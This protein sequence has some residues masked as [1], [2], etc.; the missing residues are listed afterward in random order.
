MRTFVRAR[1]DNE[2]GV[3]LVIV[4]CAMV[5]LIGMLAIA[6]DG[7]YGFVQNRRAQNASDFAAF[8]AAQELNDSTYCNGSEQPTVQ[9]VVAVIEN[10]IKTNDSSVGTA[11]KAKFL[12]G[13]PPN[14]T[15]SASFNSTDYPS[16]IPLRTCGVIVSVTPSWPSFFAGI[17]GHQRLGGYA[18]ATVAPTTVSNSGV[19]IVA[20]NEAGPH[21]VL[22]GGTGQFIVEGTIFLNTNVSQQ[23]WS[24]SSASA[25]GTVDL[26][27]ESGIVIT[28]GVNDTIEVMDNGNP[29][30][31]TIAASTPSGYSYTALQSALA[32]AIS[33]DGLCPYNPCQLNAGYNYNGDLVL[34]THDGISTASDLQVTGGDARDT[35]GLTTPTYSVNV[36]NDAV[37]A[38]ANS[39]LY[40]YGTIDTNDGTPDNGESMWPLDNC[41]EP[42]G[43]NP[44]V[45]GDGPTAPGGG[46][47]AV[48]MSCTTASS[49]VTVDYNAVD[50]QFPQESDPLNPQ[51]TKGA[52][53]D[54]A[55]AANLPT[56]NCPGM[57]TQY[58]SS[59]PAAVGGVVTLNPGVYSSPVDI[60]TSAVF[61]DCSG[62]AGE[63][64]AP[65]IYVFQGGLDIEPG[66]GDTV[67]GQDIVIATQDPYYPLGG[68]VPDPVAAPATWDGVDGN[69]APCL[70]SST[71][72]DLQSGDGSNV[73]ETSPSAPCTGTSDYGVVTYGDSTIKPT[74]QAGTGTNFSLL[75]GSSGTCPPPT[76]CTVTLTGP[77]T[78]AY[79]GQGSDGLVL[80]QDQGTQANFGFDAESGDEA[81]ITINGVVY[82]ASLPNNGS[83]ATTT[84]DFWD[85]PGGGVVFYPAGTL[86]T[87]YGT[88][89]GSS[90][91]AESA[92]SVLINGTAVVDD[93]NTD[94]T[95]NITIAGG[96]YSP[97]GANGLQ[98][99]G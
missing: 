29:Y 17:F 15:T 35:L 98:L 63:A 8:A 13:N 38:K 18:T 45:P 88:D 99:I 11:W 32:S 54:P 74:G 94:G 59:A 24:S 65:G 53:P 34:S 85:G 93:F 48:P 2:R 22:G 92:G 55:A 62:Y 7:S 37:D 31:L 61:N 19:G 30:T 28:S 91:P 51:T 78:G 50:N 52:P 80:Y 86:Q 57:A 47:P 21:E 75:I 68:N 39:N 3:V 41:F 33:S 12:I 71:Q 73:A 43:V 14:Q 95:T 82:N 60:T 79:G 46:Y 69:G 67:T 90:G 40:V 1:E 36:F 20:L 27:A 77:T 87:G 66:S 25:I 58:Y 70:P 16:V 5:V 83:A 89:W 44:G 23:P 6:I 49:N 97:P 76:P 96:S 72:T 4:A 84:M 56:D 10:L 9:D 26:V 64:A 81:N 42:E